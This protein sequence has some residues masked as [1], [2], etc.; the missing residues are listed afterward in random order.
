MALSGGGGNRTRVPR[1]F[2]DSFYVRSRFFKSRSPS[3]NRHGLGR[4]SRARSLATSVPGVTS[5]EPDLA[6]DFWDSPV[7]ARSRDYLLL[8]SQDEVFLG[9]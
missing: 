5:R 6:T 3:P 1:H 2:R 9:T 4:A 8:G 7:K